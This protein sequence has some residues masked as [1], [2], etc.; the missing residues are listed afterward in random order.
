M[1]REAALR[2]QDW[3]RQALTTWVWCGAGDPA[4]HVLASCETYRCDVA[5]GGQPGL[6]WSIAS[7]YTEPALRK[8]GHASAMLTALS[9][10]L[11]TESGAAALVL[12]SD[13][14]PRIYE[15]VGF[16]ARPAFDRVLPAEPGD[17]GVEWLTQPVAPVS[18]PAAGFDLRPTAD[19]LRWQIAHGPVVPCGARAG[20]DVIVWQRKDDHLLVLILEAPTHGVAL[21][22]AAQGIAHRMGLTHV[23]AWET[24][25]WPA[26]VGRR[27]PRKGAVPM[28]KPLAAGVDPA[29]WVDIPRGVWV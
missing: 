24:P 26:E 4:G 28:L 1:A 21:V 5:V 19:M 16:V 27:E 9:E 3:P 25:R 23:R 22:R 17:D 10:R 18:K 29:A 13:V 14:D 20:D 11:R 2:A 6:A 7:V 8:Q 12:F 15:R